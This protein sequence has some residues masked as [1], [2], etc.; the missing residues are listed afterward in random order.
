MLSHP[1]QRRPGADHELLGRPRS[2]AAP[3]PNPQGD[4]HR[5]GPVLRRL[6]GL[7]LPVELGHDEAESSGVDVEDCA[8]G[9][10]NWGLFRGGEG[11][12]E[13]TVS[14]WTC[15]FLLLA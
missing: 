10:Y 9:G 5:T 15:G 2:R 14:S 4:V 3:A 13:F 12:L 7:R 1:L 6:R 8:G 11:C